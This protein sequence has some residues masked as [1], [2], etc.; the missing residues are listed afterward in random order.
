MRAGSTFD[1]ECSLSIVELHEKQGEFKK[2]T[3]TALLQAVMRP[4]KAD[5]TDEEDQDAFSNFR[6]DV[7]E[8]SLSFPHRNRHAGV[9]VVDEATV[10]GRPDTFLDTP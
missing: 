10:L 3:D 4:S 8:T 9:V 7:D 1:M 5:K 6:L 2:K